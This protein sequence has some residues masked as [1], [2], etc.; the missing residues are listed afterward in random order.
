MIIDYREGGNGGLNKA[1]GFQLPA[2][3]GQQNV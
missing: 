1:A 3:S 2:A